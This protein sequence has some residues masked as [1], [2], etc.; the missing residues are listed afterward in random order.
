MGRCIEVLLGRCGGWLQFVILFTHQFENGGDVLVHQPGKTRLQRPRGVVLESILKDDVL[1]DGRRT[2]R[3]GKAAITPSIN[4]KKRPF[5]LPHSIITGLPTMNHAACPSIHSP[6]ASTLPRSSPEIP[7][8]ANG[9]IFCISV[10]CHPRES[11]TVV[12][13]RW[14]H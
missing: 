7:A 6:T 10:S 9:S 12:A 5:R 4:R 13:L 14:P 3:T 11:G 1:H 2:L 8:N